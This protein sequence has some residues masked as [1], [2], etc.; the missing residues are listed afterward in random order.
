MIVY[1]N[2]TNTVK[3]TKLFLLLVLPVLIFSCKDDDIDLTKSVLT[4]DDIFSLHADTFH[5]DIDTLLIDKIPL[6]NSSNSLLLG[7]YTD[8]L[9]GRTS[10]EIMTQLTCPNSTGMKFPED[11]IAGETKLILRLEFSSFVPSDSNDVITIAAYEMNLGSFD[12]PAP[13]GTSYYSNTDADI[14]SDKSILLGSITDIAKNYD[15]TIIEIPITDPNLKNKLISES[16]NNP[17]YFLNEDAFIKNVFNGIYIT[18]TSSVDKTAMFI[19][20]SVEMSIDYQYPNFSGTTIYGA[21]VFAASKEVRQINVIEN[22]YSNPLAKDSVVFLKSPAGI[23][24]VVKIPLKRI[25]DSLNITTK[26]NI[27]YLGSKKLSINNCVFTCELTDINTDTTKNI[28]SPPQYLLLINQSEKD[29]FFKNSEL[30]DGENAILA[31]LSGSSYVF[32]MRSYFKAEFKSDSML[33]IEELELVPVDVIAN[34]NGSVSSI[35]HKLGLSGAI[36]RSKNSVLPLKL[37]VL[38]SGF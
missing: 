18:L 28:L 6:K 12:I 17:S 29:V 23:N 7:V 11:T 37:D 16:I 27:A 24:A 4:S 8:S 5:I 36:I 25:K 10:A 33:D 2:K 13:S 9:Y 15:S 35:S 20:K 30:P 1:L 19:I 31:E 3:L 21:K 34:T 22:T 38:I 26:N 14:Y 32:D